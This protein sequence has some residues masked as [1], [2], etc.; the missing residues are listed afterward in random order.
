MLPLAKNRESLLGGDHLPQGRGHILK[1]LK[2]T[3]FHL[4]SVSHMYFNFETSFEKLLIWA[5]E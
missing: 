5:I 4:F 2:F 3:F 1:K